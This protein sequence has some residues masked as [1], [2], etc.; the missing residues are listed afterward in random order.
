M[1][2]EEQREKLRK[3][4]KARPDLRKI[5]LRQNRALEIAE[6]MKKKNL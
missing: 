4:Y 2:I 3:L 5:I 6:E 1:S